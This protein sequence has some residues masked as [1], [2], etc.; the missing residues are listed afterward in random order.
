MHCDGLYSW[1]VNLW[2]DRDNAQQLNQTI[3]Y[4]DLGSWIILICDNE[5][6]FYVFFVI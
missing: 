5:V 4:K 3:V 6:P 1:L 2:K